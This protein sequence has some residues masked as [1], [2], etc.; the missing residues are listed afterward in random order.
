MAVYILKRFSLDIRIHFIFLLERKKL[1][2]IVTVLRWN[3]LIVLYFSEKKDFRMKFDPI[4]CNTKTY[5]LLCQ[6]LQMNK[7]IV[8]LIQYKINLIT[9]C[10]K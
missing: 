5:P 2:P 3:D 4:R 7:Q 8:Q 6:F 9:K 10:R 1:F